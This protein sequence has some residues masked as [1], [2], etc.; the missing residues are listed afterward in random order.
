VQAE[1]DE[2]VFNLIYNDKTLISVESVTLK[3]STGK[4]L[5]QTFST[6][7]IQKNGI[8]T[9]SLRSKDTH[10]ET[11]IEV[12]CR[13]QTAVIRFSAK[14]LEKEPVF[15]KQK[16]LAQKNAVTMNCISRNAGPYTAVYQHKEWW[17]RPAFCK[18]MQD[19]PENTQLLLWKSD[20]TYFVMLAVCGKQNRTD[21]C[22]KENGF[23][24]SL[25]TNCS[26]LRDCSDIAAVITCGVNPYY[27][28][29]E[30]VR[31]A[32]E[33]TEKPYQLREDKYF[34]ELFEYLGWCSWD[35]FGHDVSETDI[36]SKLDEL[37]E[38]KIPVQWVLI[39]DGWSEVNVDKQL[40]SGLDADKKRFPNG[41]TGTIRRLKEDY[42]IRWVGVWQAVMGY[43]NGIDPNS[44]AYQELSDFLELLPDGKILPRAE[45]A[46]SFG[47]WNKWHEYLKCCGVDFV[48]VDSQSSISLFHTGRRTFGGACRGIHTGLEASAALNFDGSLIN[49]MGMAPEDIWNRPQAVLSRNSDDFVPKVSHAIRE[50]A[51]QN[52]YNSLLHGNFYWEDWDMFW[53]EHEAAKQNAI[54]RALSGGPIYLSE[55]IGQTNPDNIFPLVL[56]DG[57]ILRC[58]DVGLPTLDCLLVDPVKGTAPLKIFN[59]YG[60]NYAIGIFNISESGKPCYGSICATDIPALIDQSVWIYDWEKHSA[61]LMDKNERFQI[62]VEPD[63]AKLFLLLPQTGE[64]TILGMIEKYLSFAAIEQ[65]EKFDSEL[66]IKIPQSG[67]FVFLT[68]NAISDITM[69][70]VSVTPVIQGDLHLIECPLTGKH[71]I[72]IRH[73]GN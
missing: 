5:S 3:T 45:A 17:I 70:G 51:L 4:L 68:Q 60:E 47:F 28:I 73:S 25:S 63:G 36:L 54:L 10:S 22:G 9:F 39:D 7:N 46:Q 14:I 33:F 24:I 27:C 16:F 29:R 35:A 41:L 50:H 59:R 66:L 43:W 20:D 12:I 57:K 2:G 37:N 62:E 72:R 71:C 53:S 6:S 42:G 61:K 15:G 19:I 49:C 38:K 64:F 21:L 31:T 11:E 55:P 13:E 44:Q 30:A 32:F 56:D 1:F 26:G 69:D 65:V 18:K 67:T 52:A 40:L 34:P 8:K 58:Q 23:T 48:K